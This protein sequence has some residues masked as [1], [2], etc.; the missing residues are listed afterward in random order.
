MKRKIKREQNS[1]KK[2]ELSYGVEIKDWDFSYTFS[3]NWDERFFDGPFWEHLGIEGKGKIMCPEKLKDK[4]IV[5]KIFAN[6]RAVHILNNPEDYRHS[7]P[8][9]A[10]GELTIRGKKSEF[11]GA[12]PFD[13]FHTLCSMLVAG[14]IKYLILYGGAL[15][16]GF[17]E[18]KSMD[19][20][21]HLG[22]ED[23]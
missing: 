7:E 18:I 21:E 13:A 2:E 6:R 22:S 19:L 20:Q 5:I 1:E 10:V 9:K 14:K 8:S 12:V 15:H 11:H 4:E 23:L 3:V 17:A 16:R